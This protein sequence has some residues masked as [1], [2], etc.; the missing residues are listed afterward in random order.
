MAS[1]ATFVMKSLWKE[2]EILQ[3]L[4]WY[5][6]AYGMTVFTRVPVTGP[7]LD[8]WGP[9]CQELLEIVA[10]PNRSGQTG[11]VREFVRDE[12]EA[13]LATG[14][15]VQPVLAI[16]YA[17]RPCYGYLA[18]RQAFVARTWHPD[19]PIQPL[20]LAKPDEARTNVSPAYFAAGFDIL[21]AGGEDPVPRKAGAFK[22]HQDPWENPET[23][24]DRTLNALWNARE[25]RGWWLAEVG[26][27]TGA[28]R[29]IDAVVVDWPEPRHS[30]EGADVEELGRE[31]SRGLDAKLIEAKK[32][33]DVATIGQLLCGA[34]MLAESLPGHG[35]LTLTAAVPVAT[36]EPLIWFCKRFGIR[37]EGLE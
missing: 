15:P 4:N 21:V 20:A 27:G 16:G 11:T 19:G 14:L 34:Q 18:T 25:R 5:A 1:P 28:P 2:S 9:D 26:V 29:R 3:A 6:D 23:G 35:R 7:G 17:D 31:L 22:G 37:I 10:V 12:F 36:E 30:S 13:A 24:E 8:P 33:L 32:K